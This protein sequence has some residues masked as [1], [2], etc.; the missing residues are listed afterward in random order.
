MK[1]LV[2]GA[3][4][5]GTASA[6]YL[7]R[8]GHQ[9]TVVDRQP[10]SGLE[11][12]FANAGHISASQARPWAQPDAPLKMLQWLGREDAPLLFRLRADAAQWAW[13]LQFLRECLPWRNHR[14]TR[15]LLRLA[16]HSRACLQALR[17]E[18][19]IEYDAQTRGILHLHGSHRSLVRAADQARAHADLGGQVEV[20]SAAQCH[21]VEP[22]LTASQLPF[23]GGTYA[24]GDESGDAHAFTR[25]LER[26]SFAH[27][28]QFR[29]GGTVCGFDVAGDRLEGVRIR[30][31]WGETSVLRADAYLCCLGVESPLHLAPLG[32]R[33]PV[34]PVK[35]YSVT[36]PVERA[37][38]APVVGVTHEAFKIFCSRLGSRLR[39]AG[40]A[41]W[42]GYDTRVTATR[43]DALIARAR[44]LFPDAGA[45]ESAQRWTGLRPTTPSNLPLI[46]ATRYANLFLNTGHG[47]LGWTLACGSGQVVADLIG[48]GRSEVDF[49]FC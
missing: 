25:A 46:G 4:V 23:V 27:G 37:D 32:V 24:P 35:G 26:Y 19:G 18:T 48:G 49:P 47:P 40:T 31:L 9:V 38:R 17:S 21:R 10:V 41:E 20:L 45:F 34:Y 15:H 16:L 11:T 1:I 8:V 12:S 36:I 3:G 33:V 6:W 42:A 14:N 29:F 44:Q 43:C 22:A 28:V 30:W 39:V 13:G 7:H 5:V 2:L